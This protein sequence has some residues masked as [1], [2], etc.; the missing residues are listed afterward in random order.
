VWQDLGLSLLQQANL[1]Q[2]TTS[3]DGNAFLDLWDRRL[4]DR[5]IKN[6]R[7]CLDMAGKLTLSLKALDAGITAD[8]L[9]VDV[10]QA[11]GLHGRGDGMVQ[12]CSGHS[13]PSSESWLEPLEIKSAGEKKDRPGTHVFKKI[14]TLGASWKHLFLLARP[15]ADSGSIRGWRHVS[16]FQDSMW[17]GYVTRSDFDAAL[18]RAGLDAPAVDV[19]LTPGSSRGRSWLADSVKWIRLNALTHQWWRENVACAV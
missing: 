8:E 10:A 13:S 4:Q 7:D 3:S 9:L 14:R 18:S 6:N 19:T 17:L 5:L 12:R 16:D 11:G 1:L 15:R 2:I